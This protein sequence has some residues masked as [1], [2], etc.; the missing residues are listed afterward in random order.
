VQRTQNQKRYEREKQ[1]NPQ[2]RKR[3]KVYDLPNRIAMFAGYM[4]LAALDDPLVRDYDISRIEARA[5][6]RNKSM[7]A[8]GF[9]LITEDEYKQFYAVVDEL[10]DRF[11]TVTQAKQSQCPDR[12]TWEQT[13]QFVC[14]FAHEA[15]E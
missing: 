7:L 5:E 6:T 10:L 1:Q 11:F 15:E 14:P 4:L 12:Q 3:N 13:Y 8:H 2:A 9:R